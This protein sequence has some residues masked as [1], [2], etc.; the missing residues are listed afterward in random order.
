MTIRH[1]SASSW[2]NK[3]ATFRSRTELR[4][5]D[6]LASAEQPSQNGEILPPP[7]PVIS[8]PSYVRDG[9][10]GASTLAP[11]LSSAEI[12]QNLWT[13]DSSFIHLFAEGDFYMVHPHF[14]ANP[15][16]SISHRQGAAS[17]G[18]ATTTFDYHVPDSLLTRFQIIF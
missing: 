17:S 2:L 3:V 13:H 12:L 11:P 4:I 5:R 18:Q 9:M 7:S 14:S 10:P 6:A 15:A 8:N 1:G 16:Y